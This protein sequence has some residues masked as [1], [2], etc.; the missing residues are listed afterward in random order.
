M[1]IKKIV[2]TGNEGFLYRHQSLFQSMSPYFQQLECLPC[3]ELYEAK[4]PKLLA[5]VVYKGIYTFSLSQ[6]DR[7]FNKNQLAYKLKSQ[8]A[9]QKIQQLKYKPDLVFQVFG[10]YSP[11]WEDST[12][13]YVV[14]LDYT[15]ALAAKNWSPW[16]PFNKDRER[17]EWLEC[18]RQNYSKAYHLF[19]MSQLVK[20]SLIKDYGVNPD[21]ITVVGSAG[22]LKKIY[23]GEKT[24]GTQQILFNGSDFERKGGELVLAAFQKV[25][26]TFPKAKLVVIGKK[27]NRQEPGL[28]NP[29]KVSASELENLFLQTDIVVSP[30]YC[31]PFPTFVLEAM[32]YGI[33]C[34][35]ANRDGM[36]EIVE[37]NVNG[38]VIPE[39]SPNLLAN[40]ITHLFSNPEKLT[41]MS[42]A[43]RNKV[44]TQFN[45]DAIAK[46]IVQVLSA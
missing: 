44:K 19:T 29:G 14:Y 24:F 26:Q 33:P 20:Q 39:Q 16:A 8:K 7:L 43:A 36:P 35:V 12:I 30:S 11:F 1:L 28:E 5:K 4:I 25:K 21:K 15:M 46:N 3:G 6:A 31:D 34:I 45:W 23:E 41:T 42:E 10:M 38:I 2:V 22:N 32:N 27:L 37:H 13:P 9:E 17:E 40:A 18:E